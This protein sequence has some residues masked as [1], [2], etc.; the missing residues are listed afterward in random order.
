[1][2]PENSH[3]FCFLLLSF[4]ERLSQLSWIIR[5]PLREPFSELFTKINSGNKLKSHLNQCKG[6]LKKSRATVN[7][8]KTKSE[9]H[10]S[11]SENKTEGTVN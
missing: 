1:M 7:K 10:G 5:R 9:K 3:V 11:E 2:T 4:P 6:D 8:K